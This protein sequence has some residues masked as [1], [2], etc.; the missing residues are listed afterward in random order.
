MSHRFRLSRCVVDL[1]RAVAVWPE[2]E[3]ALQPMHVDLLRYLVDA[4][5]R[6][7]S[8]RELLEHVFQVH[9]DSRSRA[10][11]TTLSRLRKLIEETP[12]KP[13]HVVR[14][15]KVG[16]RLQGAE[17]LDAPASD[18]EEVALSPVERRAVDGLCLVEGAPGLELALLVLDESDDEDVRA[19]DAEVVGR[20]FVDRSL[21]DAVREEGTPGK[22]E[23]AQRAW[24]AGATRF[25]GRGMEAHEKGDADAHDRLR[26][27]IPV[28]VEL[29][30]KTR[31]ADF[32]ALLSQLRYVGVVEMRAGPVLDALLAERAEP[33]M[34][35]AITRMLSSMGRF[36]DLEAHVRP[37]MALPDM[38][39]WFRAEAATHAAEAYQRLGHMEQAE[40]SALLAVRLSRQSE[41]LDAIGYA[42]NR[43]GSI[44]RLTG[45][46]S[47]A[48]MAYEE[49]IHAFERSGTDGLWSAVGN[50]ANLHAEREEHEAAM[51]LTRR[52]V[53]ARPTN[54][55]TRQIAV[56]NLALHLIHL[57]RHDEAEAHIASVE[58]EGV[59]RDEHVTAVARIARLRLL[60]S[61]GTWAEAR[62]FSGKAL[63]S[64]WS[65]ESPRHLGHVQT[66]CAL[67]AEMCGDRDT[68]SVR[69]ADA[70]RSHE[71]V[72]VRRQTSL[73]AL[74]AAVAQARAVP[75][76]W[77]P[78]LQLS[79]RR[80][81]E[82]VEGP[83]TFEARCTRA[84]L[85]RHG[86][87]PSG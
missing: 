47:E 15:Y 40:A 69:F 60:L 75:D 83:P 65:M 72:K 54:L 14:R 66:L 37:L 61:R 62:D 31:S 70:L 56:C 35:L 20:W 76:P 28:L 27:L 46:L 64:A 6:F 71:T 38:P 86:L 84:L 68:A 73:T 48:E 29:V 77:P 22:S 49:S 80:V 7:V 10:L 11:D 36:V 82:G 78:G 58:R 23:W 81:L 16:V 87:D 42:T 4:G 44:Y 30:T 1:E 25:T 59:L 33:G 50:R 5:P 51:A 8:R 3:A 17:W 9:P 34:A 26:S 21:R 43:M 19:L 57:G 13:V 63:R 41:D 53:D 45:R 32:A 39:L 24:L 12:S 67:A 74:W 18:E 55:R 2:R 52:A 85:R 79:V